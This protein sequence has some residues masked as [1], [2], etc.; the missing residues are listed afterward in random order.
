MCVKT[1]YYTFAIIRYCNITFNAYFIKNIVQLASYNMKTLKIQFLLIFIALFLSSAQAQK[2]FTISQTINWHVVKP[3]EGQEGKPYI[4]FDNASLQNVASPTP[5]YSHIFELD[6]PAKVTAELTGYE[7][8]PILPEELAAINPADVPSKFTPNIYYFT[9][10]RKPAGRLLFIPLMVD[11]NTGEIKKITSFT[12]T[13]TAT[14][15]LEATTAA[16][17]TWAENSV[18]ANGKWAKL[19]IAKEGVH[20]VTVSQL[21]DAGVNA[22][23]A[24][25]TAIR[26]YGNG[27]GMLPQANLG[28]KN[29]DLVENPIEVKDFNQNG[30]FDGNDYLLFYA[31]GPNVW[32]FDYTTLKYKHRPHKYA[33]RNYYYVTVGAAGGKRIADQ[34]EDAGTPTNTTTTF[35]A[36]YFQEKDLENLLESGRE[37]FGEKFDKVLSY[38]FTFEIPDLDVTQPI[39]MR[40][41]VIGRSPVNMS[42]ATTCNGQPVLNHLIN[43]INF[44]YEGNFID[45]PDTTEGSFFVTGNTLNLKYSLN[46][47][48]PTCTA[49]LNFFEIAARR[50]MRFNGGGQVIIRDN[51]NIGGANITEFVFDDNG[52]NISIWEITSPLDAKRQTHRRNGQQRRFTLETKRLRTFVAFDDATLQRPEAVTAVENQNLHGLRNIE[53]VI[54][55]HPDF[56]TAAEKLAEHHKDFDGLNTVV[57]TPQQ[58]YNEFS[59]G[60]QDVSAIRNFLKMFY[61]R[62]GQTDS[63][64]YLLMFG[65]ASYD[66]KDRLAKNTNFVP[67]YQSRNIYSPVYSYCSDDFFTH[68][69]DNEGEWDENGGMDE[70]S[71]IGVGRLPVQTAEQAQQMVD[72]IIRYTNNKSFGSWRNEVCFIADDEDG[73]E[74]FKD[75]QTFSGIVERD[76]RNYNTDK[77]YLDA[78]KQVSVGNGTRYPDVNKQITRRIT[79]GALVVNYN[80]HGGEL[81]LAHEQ[82]IDIP[83]IN[84]WNNPYNMPLFIT[85]TCEFSRFDDPGRTSA[86][87]LVLLNPNGGGIA[88]FTTV[89]LVYQYPNHILNK[90]VYEKNIFSLHNGRIPRLGDVFKTAK[91]KELSL[92]SRNFTLLGDPAVTLAYPSQKVVTTE[93]NGTPANGTASDTAHALSK[94]TIKGEVQDHNGNRLTGFNGTVYPIVFDKESKLTTLANDPTSN[95]LPFGMYKNII[96][97]GKASV[98]NGEFEFSFIVPQDI[99]YSKGSSK[100]SYYAN[101]TDVDAHGYYDSLIVTGTEQGAP[102]DTK[103]P[104]VR[105]FM[106]DTSFRFGGVTNESPTLLALVTDLHGINTT[107]NGIGRDLTAILD[108]DRGSMMILNDYYQATLDSYQSGEIRYPLSGLSEGLHSIKVKVWDVYNNS[109]EGYTEFVV[110]NSEKLAI[111][112]LMNYPNPFTDKTTFYFEHNKQGKELTVDVEIYTL[113][114]QLLKSMNTVIPNA[115]ANVD[116]L[117]WDIANDYGNNIAQGLYLFRVKV[118]CGNDT[119]EQ[120]EKMV[121]IK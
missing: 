3:A 111:K 30:K 116:G 96:Y 44:S 108:G 34:A 63:I 97:K 90:A 98:K 45:I 29:D 13:L 69:D 117:E 95:K 64:R 58:V 119:V 11:N 120:T 109:A 27:G 51:K 28:A 65:D 80:G 59:S 106:N 79:Q 83:M 8:A 74:H 7:L 15:S 24:D 61:D 91:N 37:W 23:G 81:G 89:R 52:Q 40:S 39:R 112:R 33:D 60:K 105:L 32:E 62:P 20:R 57:V 36:L 41:Q 42:V 47:P 104:T 49:W 16:A 113:N 2:V 93:I 55:A 84:A 87:E 38:D 85:A 102:V 19:T 12:I 56:L 14:P 21:A 75:G 92:N 107:G 50:Q 70:T 118:R 73:N 5:S 103:G 18:L 31:E 68:M 1:S 66:Y 77:I 9:L 110:E 86:G 115:S 71:D 54:V 99:S 82:I 94:V 10:D 88:L 25:I 43:G 53:M 78:F 67:T 76:Y 100:I 72:K 114:G 6:Y 35:D 101:T 17:Y 121:L 26:L 46:K 4:T 48:A 22:N